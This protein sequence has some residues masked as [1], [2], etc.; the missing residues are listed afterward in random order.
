MKYAY[1]PGCSLHSTA[2]EYDVSARLA[3]SDLGIELE[4]LEDWNCCGASAAHNTDH[5]LSVAMPARDLVKAEEQGLD[6]AA[7][8]AACYNRL[9]IA[10]HELLNDPE[11]RERV[12]KLLGIEY[13]G[14]SRAYS[15][16]DI[17]ANKYGV[18]ALASAIK[19]PLNGLRAAAYYGCLL[20]RP[21]KVVKFDDPENPL[22][23]DR[24]VEALG[25]KAVEWPFKTECCGASL[26]ITRTRVVWQLAAQ[27]LT[28]AQKA[29]AEAIV[30]ACPFCQSNLDMRQVQ[31]Q[32]WSGRRWNIPVYYFTQL[33]GVALGLP[34]GELGLES[35][36]VDPLGVLRQKALV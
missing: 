30:V 11:T 29:G 10:E 16:L 4:E 9:A 24:L 20:V 15:L 6:I 22:S 17:V 18:D 13:K 8:C 21:P 31:A 33:L 2:K 32:K 27:I 36:F 1:Y 35:H 25:A 28:A 5:F 14:K 34:P 12:K 7:P 19:K 3:C 23:L 26:S